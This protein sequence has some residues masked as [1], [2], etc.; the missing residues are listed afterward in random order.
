MAG[1][2]FSWNFLG[3]F[4]LFIFFIR[5]KLV[6]PKNNP[7][8]ALSYLDDWWSMGGLSAD[9]RGTRQGPITHASLPVPTLA[10]PRPLPPS[11]RH[12][13]LLSTVWP[14]SSHEVDAVRK[15]KE[16]LTAAKE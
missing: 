5:S 12:C 8:S 1:G 6:M 9:G 4:S 11:G 3:Y 14:L 16:R 15:E 10:P 2:L 7:C 13:V